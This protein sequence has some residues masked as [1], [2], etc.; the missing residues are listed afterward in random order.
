[1]GERA[2]DI[3]SF[4]RVDDAMARVS[5]ERPSD[6]WHHAG[7]ACVSPGEGRLFV[8]LECA[9]A[10]G[11]GAASPLLVSKVCAPTLT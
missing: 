1:V 5:D 11:A 10:A 9:A 4:V 6:G 3:D 8:H 7:L 2:L